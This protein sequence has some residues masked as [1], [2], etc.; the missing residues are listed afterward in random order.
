MVV[1][2]LA[3]GVGCVVWM[4][5]VRGFSAR[6]KPSPHEAMMA[7]MARHY[8]TPRAMR[9]AVN[10]VRY[11]PEILS[12]ARAHWAD[13][14]A[15]CHGNDGKGR[16]QIGG[17]LYPP[18]PDMTLSDT[19]SLRDGELFSIIENGIRLTGMPGWGDGTAESVQESWQL[20]HFIRH[21]PKLS[22]DELVEM[23]KLTPRSRAEF[24]QMNAEEQ[25]LAGAVPP[26]GVAPEHEQGQHHH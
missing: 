8:A 22:A 9:D 25:F 24:E 5:L 11:S 10:P 20:V 4:S 21:L 13:H 6:D 26:Q 15:T 16:T 23:E 12:E 1:A 3:I 7:R 17:N 18:A 14:C 2:G 19:Q